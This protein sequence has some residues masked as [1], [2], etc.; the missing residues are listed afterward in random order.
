M[1]PARPGRPARFKWFLLPLPRGRGCWGVITYL[2]IFACLFLVYGGLGIKA[3]VDG[4]NDRPVLA[5]QTAEAHYELGVAHM[6]AGEYELAEAEFNMALMLDHTVNQAREQLHAVKATLA[7][8]PTPTSELYLQVVNSKLSEAEALIGEQKWAEAVEILIQ[9]RDLAPNFET[10]R[11]SDLLALAGQNLA[12]QYFATAEALIQQQQW[13]AA[14]E[15]LTRLRALDPQFQ[16]DRVAEWLYLAHYNLGTLYVTSG[17][18]EEAVHEFERARDERPGDPEASRQVDMASLY[19]AAM[20]VWGKDWAAVIDYLEQLFTLSTDYLDVRTRLYQAYDTYG[21]QLA[22][23]RDWCQ[24]EKQYAVLMQGDIVSPPA[25]DLPAKYAQTHEACL[26]PA[27]A[28]EL[29]SGTSPAAAA[30]LPAGNAGRASAAGAIFFSRYNAEQKSWEVV[31]V[32]SQGG[33]PVLVL[34]QA[35]QPALSPDGRWL[36]YH[37]ERS[38]S[39]GLHAFDLTSGADIR[40]TTFGEDVTPDWAPDSQRLVFPSQRSGDRRWRVYIGWADGKSEANPL[41]EGRTPAWS[42][43][44]AYIAYQ[45]TDAQG[46]NPGLYLLREGG[47]PM[48]LTDGESDRAPAWSPRCATAVE[49][50]SALGASEAAVEASRAKQKAPCQIAFMR[51]TEGSWQVYVMSLPQ[52][53]P[54]P[55]TRPP[56]NYGL[57]AWSPDAQQLAMVSDRDGSWGVYVASLDGE[58]LTRLADWDG[59]RSDWLLERLSWAR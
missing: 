25:A 34:D 43:D 55:V 57:P 15:P 40:S 3:V 54:Q 42:P 28:A 37:S 4:L 44:G 7:A 10:Q 20:A 51:N 31:R 41:S 32:S 1:R 52:G 13:A 45:G 47:T 26:N 12:E 48:R 14:I 2:A 21:D 5:R 11:V 58:R 23:Q 35:T 29:T 27:R 46:N 53:I 39:I 59:P 38:E 22:A 24:A 50:Q 33:T 36:A 8:R 18:V 9:V 17:R 16:A 6:Q 56:G 19:V 30:T 49:W